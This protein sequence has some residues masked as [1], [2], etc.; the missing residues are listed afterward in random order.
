MNEIGNL[1]LGL[2]FYV[3]RVS[4][5]A[6]ASQLSGSIRYFKQPYSRH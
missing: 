6:Q 3:T 1:N 2:E 4:T 5:S